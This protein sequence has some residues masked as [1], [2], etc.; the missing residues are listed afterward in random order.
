M[1]DRF[2]QGLRFEPGR[3]LVSV[4]GEIMY[5]NEKIETVCWLLYKFQAERNVWAI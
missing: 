4:Q 2:K 5:V 3:V 1:R